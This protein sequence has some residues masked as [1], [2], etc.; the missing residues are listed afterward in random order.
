MRLRGKLLLVT[1]VV[2]VLPLLGLQFVAGVERLLR[3]G[4]EQALLDS[5]AALSALVPA[6]AVV[7]AAS[8]PLY[9][10]AA[11]APLLL[12]GYGDDW[13]SW[14]SITERFPQPGVRRQQPPGV[15]LSDGFSLALAESP[16]G[17]YLL[18]RVADDDVRFAAPGRAGERLSLALSGPA[19]RQRVVIEPAAPGAFSRPDGVGLGIVGNWQVHAQGWNAEL[20]I[21]RRYRIDALGVAVVD[22]DVGGEHAT[23]TRLG[24]ERAVPLVRRDPAL[25]APLD[26]R[27]AAGSRAWIVDPSGY[28]LASG[29]AGE[30]RPD[31]DGEAP[32]AWQALLFERL[33]GDA[34]VEAGPPEES[35]A[36]IAG[37]DV[38]AARTGRT[39][40][41]WMMEREGPR[42]GARV[43]VAVPLARADGALLVLERDA[44][45]LMLLASE[46][47]LRLAG[48]T[49]LTFTAAA[50]VL[51]A[52]AAWLSWRIRRLQRSTETAVGD[53]GRV[54]AR[55]TP[56]RGSDELAGLSRSMARL[57]D[58]LRTHQQYLR[59]LAD[60][61]AHE[62]RTPLAMIDSSLDNLGRQL[63]AGDG[64]DRERMRR[65]IERAGQ[66]S[67]RLNR[68]FGAMNQAARL[69]EALIDEP[70][71]RFDL[72][73]MAADYC[74]ARGTGD[75]ALRAP[76]A[77]SPAIVRGSPDLMAQLLDKL[78][79][80][81]LG[82][83]PPGGRIDVTVTQDGGRVVLAVDNVGPRI[84]PEDVE[85]LFEPMV[86]H[87]RS[88][89]DV[90]H[91]GLGLF[92]AR[93]IAERHG[94]RITASPT[95]EGSRFAV[96]LPAAAVAER[97]DQP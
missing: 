19:G 92:I 48:A 77:G 94:G 65:Y 71:E 49:L 14:L 23:T 32:S 89:A 62:L 67:R 34:L 31:D 36:R 47:V 68:I 37:A 96:V 2:V 53:D 64:V 6:P 86:S 69:E 17:L 58:R 46:A 18:V 11:S 5:A 42:P 88:T 55:L 54:V 25:A 4:Q 63:D 15:A 90:P 70:F 76:A 28:V 39:D 75:R 21:P 85:T 38:E 91:L 73:A 84:D 50:A 83:T 16:A 66:G 52:F 60:R 74:A 29:R 1:L 80:N 41:L 22:V 43:R 3:Q 10:H 44:D 59:T 12:D 13:Q 8:A 95:D 35:A 78:V 7:P 72:A 51:L 56:Q 40:P 27:L 93:L 24:L 26:R 30:R 79:D 57:L 45:A 61:L 82:F 87:R 81:A 97:G 20:R 33:A 9:V